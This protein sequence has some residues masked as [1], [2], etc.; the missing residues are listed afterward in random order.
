MTYKGTVQWFC[1]EQGFGVIVNDANRKNVFVHYSE[2]A[3]E[4]V[5]SLI[6][7]ETVVYDIRRD[8]K[9]SSKINAV[10]VCPLKCYAKRLRKA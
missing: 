2:I 1:P 10:N 7:G 5:E 3:S 8:L 9:N 6:E 4:G